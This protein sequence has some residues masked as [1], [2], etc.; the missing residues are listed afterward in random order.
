LKGS[1][2]TNTKGC[3]LDSK[4]F[5][6]PAFFTGK[7]Q[8]QKDDWYNKY[9]AM[10]PTIHG[11]CESACYLKGIFGCSSYYSIKPATAQEAACKKNKYC[12]W[13]GSMCQQLL[14]GTDAWGQA[15]ARAGKLCPTLSKDVNTCRGKSPIGAI[16]QTGRVQQY[17][18]WVQPTT[19]FACPV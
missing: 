8:A 5:C 19:G 18:N 9:R 14:M 1:A 16:I 13:D 17:K 11:T 6:T 15:A 12:T 3:A 7:T 10:D 4:G 2:C